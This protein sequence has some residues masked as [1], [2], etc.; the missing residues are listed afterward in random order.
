MH[1]QCRQSLQAAENRL[2]RLTPNEVDVNDLHSVGRH[3]ERWLFDN[4]MTDVDNQIGG[5]DTAMHKVASGK[6]RVP[7]NSG[8]FSSTTPLP[9]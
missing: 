7:M 6:S 1:W 3:E 5:L 4:V 9:I 8:S 2:D